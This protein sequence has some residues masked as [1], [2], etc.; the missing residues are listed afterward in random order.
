[1]WEHDIPTLALG[2]ASAMLAEVT[3]FERLLT[4]FATTTTRRF[5]G[6]IQQFP[7]D[8]L[9]EPVGQFVTHWPRCLLSRIRH[10]GLRSAS[11]LSGD[12][13]LRCS[14]GHCR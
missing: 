12:L 9:K 13:I 1:M 7:E 3:K 5:V 6:T 10:I 14:P 8:Q 11:I 4:D 2:R